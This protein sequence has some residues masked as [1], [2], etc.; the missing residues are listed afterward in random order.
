MD[1]LDSRVLSYVDCFA[2]RF[3]KAGTVKYGI[4]S[5]SVRCGLHDEN[6]FVIEV[7]ERREPGG[8]GSQHDVTVKMKAGRFVV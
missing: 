5:A 4:I 3:A 8:E 7:K 2:R 1:T 6:A